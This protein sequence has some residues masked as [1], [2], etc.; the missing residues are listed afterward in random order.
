MSKTTTRHSIREN[1]CVGA[2]DVRRY[3]IPL[4]NEGDSNPHERLPQ[5]SEMGKIKS[6]DNQTLGS[7]EKLDLLLVGM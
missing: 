7:V 1:S 2:T 6:S 5:H 4:A 3:S